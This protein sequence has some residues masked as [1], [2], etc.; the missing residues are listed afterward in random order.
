MTLSLE[1]QR[2]IF[3]PLREDDAL[4][5]SIYRSDPEVARYQGWEAP[6]SLEKAQYLITEMADDEP[7]T[8][9]QWFKLALEL[10]ASHVLIGDFNFKIM[11]HDTRQAEIGYTL[12]RPYQGQ[13]YASEALLR[14][15]GYLF[16]DLDLHRVHANIDPDNIP[17][18]RL[19][20][21][22]GFRHE[23]TF[24]DSLWFKGRWASEDWYALLQREWK[25][26]SK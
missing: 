16:D 13:G 14:L 1:T 21:R 5:L 18:A 9:G 22:A 3:R 17:S 7:G 26:L 2:L 4:P 15:L 19:L 20:Q 11:E 25:T 6:Y 12:A 10:K 24:V 23:G 8:T